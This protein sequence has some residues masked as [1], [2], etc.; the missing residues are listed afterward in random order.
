MAANDPEGALA[1][2]RARA[3]LGAT[4]GRH[5]LA[6]E[7]AT[8]AVHLLHQLGRQAEAEPFWR[9]LADACRRLGDDNGLQQALGDHALLV[10]GRGDAIAI[11]NRGDVLTKMPGRAADAVAALEDARSLAAQW[12]LGP[13]MAELDRMLA[14]ARS[15]RPI[16]TP[17]LPGRE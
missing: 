16:S 2:L 8:T 13:M 6:R 7:S 17:R 10:L 4:L 3:N 1:D 14:R 5:D 15:Q 11:A 12:Q 9:L